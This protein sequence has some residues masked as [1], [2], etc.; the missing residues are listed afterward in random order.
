M[1]K[2]KLAAG[3]A[4]DS[5]RMRDLDVEMQELRRSQEFVRGRLSVWRELLADDN[6]SSPPAEKVVKRRPSSNDV[7]YRSLRTLVSSGT[8]WTKRL[9]VVAAA[10][11][12][13]KAFNTLLGLWEQLGYIERD[14]LRVRLTATGLTYAKA[15][16]AELDQKS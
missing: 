15:A 6:D 11:V 5:R 3:L 16:L 14:R 12:D 9:K 4:R 1:D 7:K 8:R 2:A 13:R 10:N